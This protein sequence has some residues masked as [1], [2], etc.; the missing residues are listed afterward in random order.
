MVCKYGRYLPLGMHYKTIILKYQKKTLYLGQ[1][2]FENYFGDC[3]LLH[4]SSPA[5][6]L[7]YHVY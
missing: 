7:K 3:S 6:M 4:K 5:Y 1:I 2:F